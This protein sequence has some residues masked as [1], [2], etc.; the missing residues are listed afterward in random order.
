MFLVCSNMHQFVLLHQFTIC[1]SSFYITL[2]MVENDQYLYTNPKIPFIGR[3]PF[4]K[5]EIF[6]FFDE[7]TKNGPRIIL[8]LPLNH[9]NDYRDREY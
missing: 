3:T 7:D 8:L 5:E 2:I 4:L 6:S 9:R 1:I